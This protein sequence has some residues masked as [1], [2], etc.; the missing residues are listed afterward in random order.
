MIYRTL[1]LISANDDWRIKTVCDYAHNK[2]LDYGIRYSETQP[3]TIAFNASDRE[4][5]DILLMLGLNES[6]PEELEFH[7]MME[8][9]V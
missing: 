5:K 6:S 4:W 2:K 8:A 9:A 1:R 3:P 7:R